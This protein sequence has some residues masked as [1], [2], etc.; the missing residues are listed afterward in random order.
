MTGLEMAAASL[1][2]G[3]APAAHEHAAA[4]IRGAARAAGIAPEEMRQRML[5]NAGF[6]R[7]TVRE[8]PDVSAERRRLLAA[9]AD[10]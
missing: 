1:R 3:G 5:V 2:S 4:M 7:R 8:K 6:R 10:E 9:A